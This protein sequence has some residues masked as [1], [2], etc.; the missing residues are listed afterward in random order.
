MFLGL[1][2]IVIADLMRI[3]ILSGVDKFSEGHQAW[4]G[5]AGGQENKGQEEEYVS[6]RAHSHS[7]S[8][9]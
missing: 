7:G 3:I 1:N 2:T 6:K 5:K 4:R 8:T 9:A